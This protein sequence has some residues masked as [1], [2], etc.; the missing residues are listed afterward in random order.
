MPS[1]DSGIDSVKR[2]ADENPST[3]AAATAVR[4]YVPRALRPDQWE[5]IAAF[6]T[7]IALRLHPTDDRRAIESMRTL[8]QFVHWTQTQGLPLDAELVFDPD[9]VEG[10]ISGGCSHLAEASRATRRSDLRRFGRAVTRRAPWTPQPRRLR[11]DYAVTPYTDDEVSRLLEV[12]SHQRTVVQRRRLTALLALGLGAGLFPKEAWTVTTED[13]AQMDG[14]LC[15]A[16][17]G[18]HARLV[19]VRPPHD[20]TL[21]EILDQDPDSTLL[22][23]SAPK[24]DRSRL[25]A[26]LD[27]AE[28]P[29]DCPPIRAH[30][31][32]ATWLLA[33]LSN[34]VPINE[35][36]KVAGVTT[37]KTFGHL[38]PYLPDV[39]QDE[40]FS[41]MTRR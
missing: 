37:A 5:P 40:V 20:L 4:R 29:D 16:V 32:R 13:L 38:M 11:Q 31:L 9:T 28:I 17:P 39:P 21:L 6:T 15:L 8:S 12:A 33:H 41:L 10:Y 19:P 30:R 26:L 2:H 7:G 18:E 3:E 14:V 27:R 36:A 34:R 22:G 35:L 25:N 24:W 1:S 23:F